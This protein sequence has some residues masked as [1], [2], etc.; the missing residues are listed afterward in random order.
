MSSPK[1]IDDE[2]F[3]C[4]RAGDLAGYQRATEGRKVVDFSG[5]DL[6][7]TDFRK[8]D[9]SK[10]VLRNAYLRD[11]DFRGCDLRN[12]DLE[13]AS[14]HNAHIAGAYFS[15]TLAPTEIL[16]SIQ[17]GTRLRVQKP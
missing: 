14:I 6:R 16:L 13:G 12:T 7:A 1:F 4:L 9:M 17:Q 10:L 3:K 11:A 8:I 15:D 2:A 5:V